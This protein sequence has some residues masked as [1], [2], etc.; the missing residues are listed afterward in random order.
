MTLRD[1]SAYNIQFH[2]GRPVLID[3]LSFEPLVEGRP[4]SAYGQFCRHFLAPLALMRHRDAR[5]GMMLRTKI[6]GIPLDLASK[7]LPRRTRLQWGL[8]VHV[9]AHAASQRRHAARRTDG[10]APRPTASRR[11]SHQAMLGLV[12]SLLATTRKQTWRAAESAWRDY[13]VLRESYSGESMDAKRDLVS[14]VLGNVAAEVVWDL[15]ANTG[16]FSRLAAEATG[17]RVL[18]IEMDPSAV[19]LNWRE[20]TKSGNT[21]V[22]PLLIDLA[23]PTPGR[24]GLMSSERPCRTAA[25]PMRFSPL[26]SC[27]TCPSGTTCLC[28]HC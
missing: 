15:G 1:A 26:R 27:T 5:L 7:M 25:P 18:A 28:R 21:R 6:D 19:E 10:T 20:C 23:N 8:G 14:E 24:V 12:D 22:L 11:M 2:D 13:Y 4:W 17:A 9:H 16:Q 3:T